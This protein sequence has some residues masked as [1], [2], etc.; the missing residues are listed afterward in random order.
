[1]LD[2]KIGRLEAIALIL[3]VMI[4]HIILNLPKLIIHSTS[5]G[6]ILNTIFVS[7][8]ALCIAFF[9]SK[10][11]QNFPQADIFDI[12]KFLGGKWL[13]NIIRNC[14]LMLFYFCAWSFI[15]SLFRGVTNCI[16][17]SNYC[18]YHYAFIP[19]CIDC[20]K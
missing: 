13:K 6:A 19:N 4:N 9:I 3:T 1:M 17:P 2:R 20:N 11:F 14:I 10:L 7:L 15:K 16:F 5:S 8:I 18:A 12:A